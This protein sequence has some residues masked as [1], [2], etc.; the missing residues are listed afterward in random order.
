M[1]LG[2]ENQVPR[3]ALFFQELLAPVCIGPE[4]LLMLKNVVF[5]G[6]KWRFRLT[7]GLLLA[8]EALFSL[9][10]GAF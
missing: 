2:G 10:T 3:Q 6:L 7:S 4:A 5:Y 1:L 9:F 8:W